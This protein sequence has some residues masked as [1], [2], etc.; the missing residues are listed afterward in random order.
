[1]RIALFTDSFWPQVNGVT[2]SIQNSVE[3]L[4]SQGH[5]FIIFAPKPNPFPANQPHHPNIQFV[6]LPSH[7]LP[8]YPDY[9][10]AYSF[11]KDAQKAF[12]AFHAD[13]VHI[14]T[15]FYVA[16]KGIELAKKKKIPVIGTFHTMLS[17]FLEYIPIPKL[18]HNPILK[19]ITWKYTQHIY[20][21]C[22]IITTP[23]QVLADELEEHGYKNVHVLSNPINYELFSKTKVKK[24]KGNALH[25]VYYS[26]VSFE[27]RIDVAVD[28]V[29]I[30]RDRKADVELHIVGEGPAKE[31]L[32]RQARDL[33]IA[34]HVHFDTFYP[35][36]KLV[37]VIKQY[38]IL[39]A[40]SPMET[41]G[42]YVVESMA[43]GLAI[44][45]CNKRAIPVALGKNER[46]LLFEDGNPNDC[47]NQ[48][49]K[50]IHHPEVQK[51]LVQRAKKYAQKFAR[52][53]IAKE[54]LKTYQRAK[55][56]KGAH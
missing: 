17:E 22:D 52:K 24:A 20:G 11:N 10:I 19:E 46:G 53:S 4:A 30:L 1:M 42:M 37:K 34:Q 9:L 16:R 36:N 43:A 29:K 45:G 47:A 13:V 44:V 18:K 33:G 12:D 3:T 26:R 39:V 54:W 25:L 56:G 2:I 50:L 23:T 41:F 55:A 31:S 14:H 21:K 38:D 51:K 5:H 27:K 6:W 8:T 49:D 40:P 7:P 48:I 15:P 28:A 35:Q 32:K